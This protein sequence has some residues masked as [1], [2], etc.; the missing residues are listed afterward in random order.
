[1]SASWLG[2]LA[3][4]FIFCGALALQ[5]VVLRGALQWYG[6]PT[7]PVLVDPDLLVSNLGM[8]NWE[9]LR[10]GL[11]YPDLVV[12][13]DGVPLVSNGRELRARAWDRELRRAVEEGRTRLHVTVRR[14]NTTFDTLLPLA[15]LEPTAWWLWAGGMFLLAWLYVGAALVALQTGAHRS[16]AR[17]FAVTACF[18]ALFLFCLFDFH[19]SRQV[20]PLFEVGFAMVPVCL[21]VLPL[22]LPDDVSWLSRRTW[23]FG[24]AEAIGALLA[25]GMLWERERGHATTPLRSACTTLLGLGFIGFGATLLARFL[26]AEGSR[27][28]QLRSF[29]MATAPVHVLVGVGFVFAALELAGSTTLFL[30]TPVLASTPLVTLLAFVRHDIWRSNALLSRPTT[31]AVITLIAC[32]AAVAVGAFAS[33]MH[34]EP[35]VGSLLASTLAVAVAV[36]LLRFLLGGGDRILF[37]ARAQYKPTIEQL[38]EE[39]KLVRDPAE[40]T[41]AI[42]RTV[43]RWLPCDDVELVVHASPIEVGDD[44]IS[45][46]AEEGKKSL[47]LQVTILRE[48]LA[49]LNV[50][51]KHGG[52][53]F[54]SEDIDLL[55]TITNQAA[56][57][58]AYARAYA[59]LGALREQEKLAWRGEREALVRTA[60]A[61]V[62]HEIRYPINYFRSTFPRGTTG[63]AL[64]SEDV[65][66]IAGEVDRLERLS[67]RL[68]HLTTMRAPER[69]DVALDDLARTTELLLSERLAGRRLDVR[70][71]RGHLRADRDQLIQVLTNLVANALDAAGPTGRV[72]LGWEST[73]SGGSLYVWDNGPGFGEDAGRLFTPWFTTKKDGTGLGLAI[74]N[75]FVM[76]HGW[77]IHAQRRGDETRFDI[78]VPGEDVHLDG[79][80]VIS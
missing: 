42:E 18:C 9:G 53:L 65:E 75:R 66:I 41:R 64:D 69:K 68:R 1:M 63:V 19:T 31:R 25:L 40:V 60:A 26:R 4:I 16:L 71:M 67:Q 7:P 52:A 54:T 59:E 36:V 6:T 8:P 21:L 34:G 62:A 72:G 48:E 56:L 44:R 61:E 15:P 33:S 38:S 11:R 55:R 24:V 12:A 5:A 39:L 57:A 49:R 29:V 22:R 47:S 78:A 32:V 46:G 73:E 70:D 27:R 51:Q 50:G 28:M 17:T 30:L 3:S 77:S 80:V 58:M 2:R 43:R 35:I 76:A 14:G 20:V 13:I 45:V 74:A 23:L 79:Q 10:D 37:P